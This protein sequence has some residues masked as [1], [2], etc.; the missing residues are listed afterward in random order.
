MLIQSLI[1]FAV[2]I[3]IVAGLFWLNFKSFEVLSLETASFYAMRAEYLTKN[4]TV[5]AHNAISKFG[6][7]GRQSVAIKKHSTESPNYRLFYPDDGT[8]IIFGSHFKLEKPYEAES[9]GIVH[10]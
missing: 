2:C 8:A 1:E 4:Q 9:L 7:R 3:L 5:A 6:K 10:E